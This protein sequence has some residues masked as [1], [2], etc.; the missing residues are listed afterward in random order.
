MGIEFS[1]LA[2]A[3]TYVKPNLHPSQPVPYAF[4]IFRN[5]R[6]KETEDNVSNPCAHI[7]PRFI[8]IKLHQSKDSAPS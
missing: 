3:E 7:L 6:K 4:P 8:S 5:N 1:I 2:F